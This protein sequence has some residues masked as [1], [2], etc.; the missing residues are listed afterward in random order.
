MARVATGESVIA[1]VVRVLD[2]F[3]PDERVLRVSEIAERA[4]L[5]IATT[6]RLVAELVAHG[7]LS[8]DTYGGVRVGLRMWELS[9]RASPTAFLRDAAMPFLEDVHAVI[10][11]HVQLG[12]LNGTDVLFLERLTAAGAVVNVTRVAGRLPLYASSSGLVLLAHAPVDLRDSVAAGPFERYTAHSIDSAARLD[13]VLADV[14]RD[15][16]VVCPGYIHPDALGVAVPVWDPARRVVAAALGAVVPNDPGRG[17]GL[18]PTLEAAARGISRRLVG[19]EGI[20]SREPAAPRGRT[21][22]AFDG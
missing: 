7:M 11:Q 10:G 1:R 4:D 8:R 5:H 14:R 19:L 9:S 3:G 20:R 12:V 15:G 16:H 13:A 17:P 22:V 6:S 18:V 21:A 2:A